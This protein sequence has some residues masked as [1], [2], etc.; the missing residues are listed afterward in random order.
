MDKVQVSTAETLGEAT[1]SD[2]HQNIDNFSTLSSTE[3]SKTIV[4]DEAEALKLKK[5]KKLGRILTFIG[6][7]ISLFLAA[8]DGYTYTNFF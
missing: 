5:K 2:I 3:E 6:L 7:Q 4:S 1:T 8:L